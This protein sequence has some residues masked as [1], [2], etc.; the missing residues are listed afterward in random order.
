M[1]G[2]QACVQY[3]REREGGREG[4]RDIER[5]LEGREPEI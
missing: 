1:L 3:K 2:Q 5:Y 4:D